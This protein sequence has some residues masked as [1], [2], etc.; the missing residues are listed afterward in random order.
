MKRHSQNTVV[1]VKDV[2]GAIAL[3][4]FWAILAYPIS[5]ALATSRIT[6]LV[7][8]CVL[9]GVVLVPVARWAWGI[10]A[11]LKPRR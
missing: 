1:H 6:T 10:V 7:I 11:T 3:V 8:Y 9:S 5:E 2:L 4:L